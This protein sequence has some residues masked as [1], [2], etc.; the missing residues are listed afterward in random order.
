MFPEI[1]A[2]AAGAVA[3]VGVRLGLVADSN[4]LRTPERTSRLRC[5][6]REFPKE[7][8]HLWVTRIHC[9]VAE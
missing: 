2:A 1:S 8:P 5:I 4:R 6:R 7:L 9:L 3:V